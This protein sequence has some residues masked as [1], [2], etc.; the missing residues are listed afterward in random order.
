MVTGLDTRSNTVHRSLV[1][2][3]RGRLFDSDNSHR[4]VSSQRQ[5]GS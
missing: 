4:Y 2:T 3:V 5:K 1:G